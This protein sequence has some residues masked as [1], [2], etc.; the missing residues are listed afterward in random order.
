MTN[1]KATIV[2]RQFAKPSFIGLFVCSIFRCFAFAYARDSVKILSTIETLLLLQLPLIDVASVVVG[3]VMFSSL[4]RARLRRRN[5]SERTVKKRL[6]CSEAAF[7]AEGFSSKYFLKN[8]S[9]SSFLS[10]SFSE[11]SR[12]DLYAVRSSI[13]RAV[14]SFSVLM[15]GSI[16]SS[17][18]C[19]AFSRYLRSFSVT[20]GTIAEIPSRLCCP[21]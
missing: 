10:F 5:A 17:L 14:L 19:I 12:M 11:L 15:R 7:A 8:W 21:I 4:V 20:A 13:T 16:N 6:T 3:E 18:S 2:V 9:L 1:I